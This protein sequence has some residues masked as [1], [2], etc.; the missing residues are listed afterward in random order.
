[1][2]LQSFLLVIQVILALSLISLILLQ[3]GRGAQAGAA[4]GS[5]ASST[6][7]GA[8]G[9][10][11]FLVKITTLLA[12][13]F[14]INSLGLA[15]LS[16]KQPAPQSLVDQL[17]LEPVDTSTLEPT[18]QSDIPADKTLLEDVQVDV[19]AA[20]ENTDATAGQAP[21]DNAGTESPADIPPVE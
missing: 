7:F 21:A 1:M 4:F 11:P 16:A 8:R 19:P 6:V 15:Y 9:A 14:F 3:H 10:V 5:G 13:V 20:E 17:Q 2:Q 18:L 12:I